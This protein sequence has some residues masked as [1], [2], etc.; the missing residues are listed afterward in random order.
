MN[1][2]PLSPLGFCSHN[3]HLVLPS[4]SLALFSPC[5]LVSM[6]QKDL[7]FDSVKPSKFLLFVFR[8]ADDLSPFP[9][10]P[11]SVFTGADICSPIILTHLLEK[12]V[13]ILVLHSAVPDLCREALRTMPTIPCIL[14]SSD[15]S[16]SNFWGSLP[17]F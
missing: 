11:I 17:I 16:M 10:M 7:V 8:F 4:L 3:V 12:R 5:I 2:G 13:A 9:D 14:S 6:S 1:S 15:L